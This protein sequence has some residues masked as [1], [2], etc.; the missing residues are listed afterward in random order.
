MNAELSQVP[1][2]RCIRY[3]V[4]WLAVGQTYVGCLLALCCA[5][6]MQSCTVLTIVVEDR[7]CALV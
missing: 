1:R 5:H 7:V 6:H 4:Q 2:N 3:V